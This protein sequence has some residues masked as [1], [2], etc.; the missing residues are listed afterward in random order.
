[1]QFWCFRVVI[2]LQRVNSHYLGLDHFFSA[3][4]GSSH[5][6]PTILHANPPRYQS[7]LRATIAAVLL[8]TAALLARPEPVGTP[9]YFTAGLEKCPIRLPGA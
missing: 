2:L 4:L 5:A 3:T 1:M 6:S 8:I 7:E 9:L